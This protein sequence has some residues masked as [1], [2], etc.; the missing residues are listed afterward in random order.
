ME[1]AMGF[2]LSLNLRLTLK[3]FISP[4]PPS[5]PSSPPRPLCLAVLLDHLLAVPLSSSSPSLSPPS[6]S[7]NP[8]SN[9]VHRPSPP[10]A[11]K[12]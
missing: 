6:L 9:H 3:P 4:S 10:S 1:L 5:D 7:R 11:L 8:N 12:P 2:T